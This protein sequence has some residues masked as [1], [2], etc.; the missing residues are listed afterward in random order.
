MKKLLPFI[1]VLGFIFP[2]QP[3]NADAPIRSEYL[4]AEYE[5][6]YDRT[7]FKHWI[8]ADKNGCDT[9]QEVLI[10]EAKNI[11]YKDV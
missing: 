3:A 10:S 6:G 9:R 1:L 2:I 7:L 11:G 5:G 4:A 8:D